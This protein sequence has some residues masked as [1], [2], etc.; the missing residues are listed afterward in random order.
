MKEHRINYVPDIHMAL[1]KAEYDT[2][3]LCY[4]I[5]SRQERINEI[6]SYFHSRDTVNKY[7]DVYRQY[8]TQFF[9]TAKEKFYRSHKKEIDAYRKSKRK[10]SDLK[11]SYAD[12]KIPWK[13]LKNEYD[14]LTAETKRLSCKLSDTKNH[15][16]ELETALKY[17]DQ[18]KKNHPI[19][20]PEETISIHQTREKR[21]IRTHDLE[22]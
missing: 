18:V 17:I 8:Q 4:S 20:E 19:K 16:K 3:Q 6:A 7:R 14:H 22:L 10:L 1:D 5:S 15:I 11:R 13:S 21:I 9:K 12:N 2:G